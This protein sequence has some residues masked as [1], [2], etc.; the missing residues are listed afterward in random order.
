MTFKKADHVMFIPML[1]LLMNY[2]WKIFQII[3]IKHYKHYFTI[4]FLN[5]IQ[6]NLSLN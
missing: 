3:Y 6:Q 1:Q 2:K 5:M 4:K